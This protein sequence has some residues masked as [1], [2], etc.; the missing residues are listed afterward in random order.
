MPS[1]LVVWSVGAGA[2]LKS[3]GAGA[4]LESTRAGARLESTLLKNWSVS[5]QIWAQL[6]SGSSTEISTYWAAKNIVKKSMKK[7][8]LQSWQVDCCEVYNKYRIVTDA[9]LTPNPD[10]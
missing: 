2:R 9:T 8:F 6:K 5:S 10:Y 1:R 4:R 3:T 7:E